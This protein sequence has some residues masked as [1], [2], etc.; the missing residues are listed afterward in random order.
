MLNISS[1]IYLPFVLLPLRTVLFVHLPV[2]LF[3]I[4]LFHFFISY[5][6]HVNPLLNIFQSFGFFL[7]SDNHFLCCAEIFK[8]GII[9]LVDFTNPKV[10]MNRSREINPKIHV[11]AKKTL[12]NQCNLSKKSNVA[13]ITISDFKLY[14]RA[15]VTTTAWYWHKNRHVDQRTRIEDPEIGP[16]SYRHLIFW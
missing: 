7:L 2:A 4:L 6:K 8:F 9:S 3:V 12:N 16:V 5:S 10:I 1:H 15:S 11:E 14:C 13:S